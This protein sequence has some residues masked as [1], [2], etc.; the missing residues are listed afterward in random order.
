MRVLFTIPVVISFGIHQFEIFTQVNDTLAYEIYVIG[1]KSL[2]EIEAVINTRLNEV[3]FLNRSAPVFLFA[4]ESVPLK[5]K[6]LIRAYLKFPTQLS[7]MIILKLTTYC[8]QIVTAKVAV[9]KNV[10]SFEV[11]N[12]DDSPLLMK[13]NVV[14]RYRGARSLGFYHIS[15]N[16]L[17]DQFGKQYSF[18]PI[19]LFQERMNMLSSQ[20]AERFTPSESTSVSDPYPWLEADDPHQH[21]TDE[22]ILDKAIDLSKSALTIPEKKELMS[23]IHTHK[24]AFSLRDE[25]G[26]CPNLRV[27]IDVVDD[28]PFFVRPFPI[29]ETDKPIMDHQM[30]HLVELRILLCN[31]TSHTSPVMLIT[32]KVT[33]DKRPIVDFRLL[34]THI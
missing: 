16:K 29:A 9:Q 25:I 32:R 8:V 3:S 31:T 24:A 27:S 34:N 10:M 19:H 22:E 17:K 21:M 26:K 7:G 12:T 11:I 20:V 4:T 30:N 13:K 2:A 14:M 28:S 23:I 1:I 18:I 15:N 6:K 33:R 5:G